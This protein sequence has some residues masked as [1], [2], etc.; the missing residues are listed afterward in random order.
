M[1]QIKQAVVADIPVIEEILCDAADWMI[2]I[3]QQQWMHEQ[4]KWEWLS[5]YYSAST[6][7]HFNNRSV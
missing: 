5:K 1:I 2:N 6:I 7:R 3:N 4:A